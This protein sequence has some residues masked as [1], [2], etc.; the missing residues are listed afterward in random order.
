MTNVQVD[1]KDLSQHNNM[2]KF[3]WSNPTIIQMLHNYLIL[4]TCIIGLMKNELVVSEQQL[5]VGGTD[6]HMDR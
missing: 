3:L 2:S 1:Q 6:T 5:K 4:G